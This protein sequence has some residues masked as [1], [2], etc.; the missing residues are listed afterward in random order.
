MGLFSK[1][2][3][4]SETAPALTNG[5]S[6]PAAATIDKSASSTPQSFVSAQHSASSSSAPN[7]SAEDKPRKKSFYE[8][9]QD[10]R[11]GPGTSA[12]SDDELK[13][14]TGKT[15]EEL[16]AYAQT[17]PGVAGGQAAGSLTAG[18]TSGFGMA[19]GTGEGLGGWGLEAGK[20]PKTR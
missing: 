1:S 5:T 17:A 4:S 15:R 12:L 18:G 20:T 9:Y 6:N 3:K 13:K 19:G 14:Y 10:L 11:R 2:K 8:K 16:D 7:P